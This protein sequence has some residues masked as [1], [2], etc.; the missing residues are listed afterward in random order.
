MNVTVLAGGVG[1]ARFLEGLV[2]VMPQED[3]TV[4]SNIGDDEDFFGLRVSPDIDIV[5]YTLAHAVDAEQGWG[6]AGETYNALG[7]LKRFGYDTWFNLGDADLATLA[8]RTQMLHKG[9]SLSDATRS[10]AEAFGLDMTIL[11]VTDDRVRTMVMTDAGELSFQEYFVKRRTQDDVVSVRFDGIDVARP[12]PGVLPAILTADVIAV[13][14]SNPVVS[15]G[16]LLAVRGVRDALNQTTARVIGI[17]PIVGGK[18]IKGPADRM[19][20]SLGIEPSAAGVARAYADFLEV[21]VIDE[22]DRA[23]APE[24]E[25]AGVRAVVAQTI[26]RGP[27]EKRA[28]AEVTLGAVQ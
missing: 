1:A 7:A 17:S 4:I 28:L 21:L 8:H 14:P 16:P 24:V 22:V 9:A 26:M 3:I 25:A 11:P 27:D 19:M 15:I 10:I 23:L 18:T 13:A 12:A 5:I 2:Q 20:A 6:L